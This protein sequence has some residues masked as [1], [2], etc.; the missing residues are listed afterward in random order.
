[1]TGREVNWWIDN[2][3]WD[4]VKFQVRGHKYGHASQVWKLGP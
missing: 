3:D 2:C 4:R 1:M